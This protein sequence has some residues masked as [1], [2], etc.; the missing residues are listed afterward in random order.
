[1][2]IGLLQRPMPGG[3]R[4]ID[5]RLMEYFLGV[6]EELH[7]TRAAE[8]LGISQPTLSQQ[9]GLLE[10]RL[11]VQLFLRL[12]R[13]IY[14]TQ[15]G[16]IL[17][18][19]GEKILYELE[20]A[21]LELRELSGLRRG[22]LT[23]GCS[24]NHLVTPL[25]VSFHREYPDIELTIVDLRAEE[26]LDRLVHNML[27]VGLVYVSVTDDRFEII[28]LF[29][30][31]FVLVTSVDN[32]L[33]SLENIRFEEI[34]DLSMA[35]LPRHYLIRQFIEK[36]CTASGIKIKPVLE[37]SSLESL[38]Q[39][40]QTTSTVT[41]LTKSYLSAV[42]TDSVRQIPFH[43]P[44]PLQPV[45]IVYLREAFVDPTMREFVRHLRDHYAQL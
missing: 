5:F 25:V 39:V 11:G 38:L 42:R 6:C 30:E 23:V 13:K 12:G 41:I 27:D 8:K 18:A 43:N 22:K 24:G 45:G 28:P 20:Q 37:L 29:D 7:F 10:N 31:E 26:T 17:R 14:V 36:H 15:A 33:A 32:S 34:Q 40:V 35:L 19:H 16:E 21:K 4:L 9:I 3:A 1:M 44:I 2:M